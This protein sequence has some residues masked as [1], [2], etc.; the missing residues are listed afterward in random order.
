MFR[1]VALAAVLAPALTV[2]AQMPGPR[3]TGVQPAGIRAG[4]SVQVTLR[5]SDLDDITALQFDHPGLKAEEFVPP[6]PK[7][8]PKAD[9]KKPAPKPAKNPLIWTV[10]AAKDVPSGMHDLR[11]VTKAGISNPRAFFVSHL[12]EVVETEPND[13]ADKAQAVTIGS[14]V[15]GQSDKAADVDWF[16]FK[17]SAGKRVVIECAAEQLDG[18]MSPMLRVFDAGGEKELASNAHYAGRYALIDF[19]PPAEGEYLIKLHDFVYQGGAAEYQ[20]R[21]TVGTGAQIDF[22]LPPVVQAGKTAEVVLYGRNLPGGVAAPEAVVNGV[23]LEKLT[24]KVAAPAKAGAGRKLD[25]GLWLKPASLTVDGFDY[26]L[27]TPA[28]ESDPVLIG[29]TPHPVTVETEPNDSPEAAAAITLPCEVCGLFSRKGDADFYRF[30]AKKGEVWRIETVSAR[31]GS[32]ADPVVLIGRYETGKDGKVKITYV[33]ENVDDDP[34]V[35]GLSGGNNVIKFEARSEDPR[36]LWTVPADGDY[37]VQIRDLYGAGR[38]DARFVYRLRLAK[39][40]PD[41]RLAVI[42]PDDTVTGGMTVRRGGNQAYQVLAGRY[43]GFDETIKVEVRGLPEGVEC[44]AVYLG[45]GVNQAPLIFTASDK[46]PE[47]AGAID[48]VGTA[49]VEGRTLVREARGAVLISGSGNDQNSPRISRMTR[50]IAMAVREDGPFSLTASPVEVSVVPGGKAEFQVKLARAG[51]FNDAVALTVFNDGVMPNNNNRGT[52]LATIAKDKNEAAV[53]IPVSK[54]AA[55]GTYTYAVL[56]TGTLPPDPKAPKGSSRTKPIKVSDP[57]NP[58]TVRVVPPVEF[59]KVTAAGKLKAGDKLEL[60]FKLA[61][62]AGVKEDVKVTLEL[63][64]SVKGVTVE[65]VTLAKGAVEGR[66]VLKADPKAPAAK[67]TDL[68]LEAAVTVG[69]DTKLTVTAPVAGEIEVE[70]A[71]PP[72]PP[73]AKDSKKK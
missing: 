69:G 11:V 34:T 55:Y 17:A 23:P 54:K 35:V 5:G 58:V 68:K 51:G 42:H 40:E 39:A 12:D 10:T 38:G 72:P 66:F 8:D 4:T 27:K 73:P 32:P 29:V 13:T 22:A 9:P 33:N 46:A 30:S 50:D 56:G 71:P 37:F 52:A 48:V 61:R 70:A 31:V 15:N 16:R 47:W 19:R 45:P 25:V 59:A 21:L 18:R 24:V 2:Y 57:S 63:P 44:P 28:G 14:V 7:P 6:E 41:F 62:L 3:L 26:R 67:L 49:V 65:A 53:S 36:L 1:T 20:Y 60:P 64:K 43:D